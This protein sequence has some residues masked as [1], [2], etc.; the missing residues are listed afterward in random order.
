[1]SNDGKTRSDDRFDDIDLGGDSVDPGSARDRADSE[2]SKIT[3]EINHRI[4]QKARSAVYYT[5]G[6]NLYSLVEMGLEVVLNHLGEE[7]G[8]PFPDHAEKLK[9]GRP[10]KNI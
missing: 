4:A 1:M 2:T 7:R 8:E 9:G 6:L 3:V 5:P 10:P